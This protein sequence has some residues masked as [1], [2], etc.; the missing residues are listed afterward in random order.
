MDNVAQPDTQKT[1]EDQVQIYFR[2]PKAVKRALRM[3]A[4]EQEKTIQEVALEAILRGL[5]RSAAA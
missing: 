4:A 3:Q 5:A 2:V 1:S